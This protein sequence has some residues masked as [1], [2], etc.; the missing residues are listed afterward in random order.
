M[1]NILGML[2]FNISLLILG[3]NNL[4]GMRQIK[5]LDIFENAGAKNFHPDGLFST[6]IYGKVGEERRN[7]LFA[8]IDLKLPVFHPVIYKALVDLKEL[9][10]EILSGKGYATFNPVTKDFEAATPLTGE[11]GYSFF[12]KHF[13]ELKFEERKST[14]REFKIR[15]VNSEREG[16]MFDKFLV[17]PAGLRDFTV[18][19]NGKPEED[20]I[21]TLYRRVLS[22]SNIIGQSGGGQDTSH[23]DTTRYGLQLAVNEVYAYIINLLE[24]KSKLIQGWWA[25]R[26]VFQSTR[27]VITAN[28]QRVNKLFDDRTVTANHTVVGLHQTLR[29]I[30]PLAV[31]LLR[32][33]SQKVFVGP[34]APSLLINTKT[35][36]RE[37]VVVDADQYDKWMTQEGIESLFGRFEVESLRQDP[38]LIEG[39]YFGLIYNDGKVVKLFQGIENL[40]EGFDKKNVSPITYAELF[41][42]AIHERAKKIP[43][44]VTRYPITGFGS[45]Y[46]SWIYLKTTTKSKKLVVLNDQWEKTTV[47]ALEFPLKNTPFVNSMS[48]SSVHLARATADF[49]GDVMS[50]TAAL[51]DD[52]VAE[53][54]NVFKSKEYYV[55]VNNRITFSCETDV[56][57]LIFAEMSA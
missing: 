14:E 16:S 5:V 51:S 49:D 26:N 42:L 31:N 50:L 17:M 10:G 32:E 57:S 1:Q 3:N 48:P 53:I 13:K 7:R 24:G 19:E 34:N 37:Q 30:F 2:P 35:L 29:A 47:V 46:P 41:Y 33:Y 55:G 36:E 4:K 28:V 54:E 15:M 22:I 44:L 11:T 9:Y 21:N 52:A 38:I 20:E 18:L 56:S 45:I 27:N 39:R 40:P 6:E 8:Y 23:M 43:A 25:S 12:L